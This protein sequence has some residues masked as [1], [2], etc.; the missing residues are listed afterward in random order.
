M[1]QYYTLEQAATLLR[2]TAEQLK[3]MARKGE[4][5]AFQD[6]GTLRFRSQEIDE[7]ARSRGLGS[8]P[9]LQIRDVPPPKS[10]AGKKT[11]TRK[12]SHAQDPDEVNLGLAP[13]ASPEKGSRPSPR[14][15]G[16]PRP[17]SSKSPPPKSAGDSDVRLVSDSSD[18]DFA[19]DIDSDVK[20]EKDPG[21]KS[22]KPGKSKSPADQGD[23]G[24]RIVPLDQP[25]D[26]D[27][28]IPPS[29]SKQSGTKRPADS[30]PRRAKERDDRDVVTEEIDLDAE[31]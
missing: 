31:A 11:A 7:L 10:S 14:P 1:V 19:I 5:R 8:E 20:V 18:L 30:D 21:S 6:R 9:E 13:S 29:D 4:V 16:A 2:T 27:V 3:E 26:S 25:S 28:K 22:P 24:V 12:T 15:T 17:S 23:S